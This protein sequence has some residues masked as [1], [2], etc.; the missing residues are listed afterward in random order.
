ME[1]FIVLT[2]YLEHYKDEIIT[3]KWIR[4]TG[5][6]AADIAVF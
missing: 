2:R 3:E 5:E 1:I 6:Q 4:E